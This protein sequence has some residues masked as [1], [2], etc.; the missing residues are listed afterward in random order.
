MPVDGLISGLDTTSLIQQLM[1]IE[2]VPQSLLTAKQTKINAK[3]D[4][5]KS[6][7]A[8]MG[9][10]STAAANLATA[11]GWDLRTATSSDTD[12]ATVSASSQAGTGSLSF[13][14]TRL[15]KAHAVRSGNTI[16]ATDTVIASGGTVSLDWGDGPQDVAVGG[17][18]LAEVVAAINASDMDVKAA[19]VDTGSGYRLQI[20]ATE[21]GADS[22]FT[23]TGLDGGVGGTV[24]LAQGEDARITVGSGP[25]AYTVDSASNTFADV[26]PGVSVTVL[27]TSV[28]EVTATV[29]EDVAGLAD[30]VKELV[31]AAN[32]ALSEIT[33]ATA[34]DAETK[35]AASLAGDP[36][37]RRLAQSITRA[38]SGA[39]DG[40]LG[41][42][43]LTGV[44]LGNNGRFSF[45][46]DVFTEAYKD[47]PTGVRDTFAQNVSTTGSVTFVAAG[48]RTL[49]GTYDVE[50]TTAAERATLTG[51]TGA[52]PV[53]AG[54]EVKVKVGSTE[55]SYTFTGTESANDAATALQAAIDAAGLA[56]EVTT[57]GNSL[58]VTTDAYG[59]NAKVSVA[60][61]GV[62]W[63]T[64]AGVDVRGKVNGTSAS[65]VGRQLTVAT[66]K[67]VV[68]GVVVQVPGDVTG[69][70][71]TLTYTA[72]AAQRAA[73]ALTFALDTVD[74][75]LTATENTGKGQVEDLQDSIDAFEIR[76]TARQARLR[77]Y[78]AN[79]EVAL[80][81]LQAQ[82]NWLVGAVNSLS[83]SS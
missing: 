79:L 44:T 47:D 59:S 5:Y 3:L 16:A 57:D 68:G 72:G 22:E 4:A 32:A 83:T 49:D 38:L 35:K 51:L 37:V 21:S 50:I 61:D 8:K 58:T 15:A 31:E 77:T 2:R 52:F 9:A 17:G 75:Y 29:T 66:T 67:P 25:G 63:A 1:Q 46:E 33:I 12:V 73:S 54:Q 39:V 40:G 69:V 60:W 36:T 76:L 6:V 34:Y 78:Y 18:T 70:V 14:V 19:A 28:D 10:L 81:N 26:M 74:G 30:K 53:T 45:D 48:N 43:G 56:L 7:R 82:S 64:D 11:K 23:V 42:V 27:K 13:T 41:S 65:G 24:V 80:S 55:A 20:S 71:G 62:T